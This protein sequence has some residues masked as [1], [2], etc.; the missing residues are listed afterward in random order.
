[1]DKRYD[2]I[3]QRE[4]TG[5]PPSASTA[6]ASTTRPEPA[7]PG[8]TPEAEAA[9]STDRVNERAQSSTA[10]SSALVNVAPLGADGRRLSEESP[11][12][13]PAPDPS[14]PYLRLLVI[15]GAILTVAGAVALFW[16]GQLMTQRMMPTG[17]GDQDQAFLM[18]TYGQSLV[19]LGP[20]LL[21]LGVG[22][23]IGVIFLSAANWRTRN[24]HQKQR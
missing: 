2:A 19:T 6:P 10:E 17:I 9:A 13:P 8:E 18:F 24:E 1:M 20:F 21:A 15:V 16:G 5:A 7:W 4:H 11:A 23:L 14:N 22:T 12:A 3:Y